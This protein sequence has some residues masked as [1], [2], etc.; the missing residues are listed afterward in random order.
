VYGGV[1]C[2]SGEREGVKWVVRPW[3]SI[4]VLLRS[5][6]LGC[7]GAGLAQS[8]S[9]TCLDEFNRIDIEVLSVIAQQLMQLRQGMLQQQPVIEFEGTLCVKLCHCLLSVMH[10]VA[11][12]VCAWVGVCKVDVP[13]VT[14]P[15][16]FVDVDSYRSHDQAERALC[17]R[18][19]EPWLR[20]PH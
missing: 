3:P 13:C 11:S 14:A 5:P 15:F 4:L 16:I 9:W 18:D 2:A 6:S 19:H 8:G 17:D 7:R 1:A 20:R 12:C 10:L